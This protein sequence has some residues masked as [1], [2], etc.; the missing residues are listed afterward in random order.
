MPDARALSAIFGSESMSINNKRVVVLMVLLALGACSESPDRPGP[1]P[2]APEIEGRAEALSGAW[3]RRAIGEGAEYRDLALTPDQQE[4]ARS[5]LLERRAL[6]W[7]AVER[8]LAPTS[9]REAG[10][11]QRTV[12]AF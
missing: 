5:S 6:A 10:E 3:A 12:P 1:L 4:A 9:L 8:V 2:D 7:Q 11:L